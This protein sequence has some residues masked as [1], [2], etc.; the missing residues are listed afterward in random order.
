MKILKIYLFHFRNQ[1]MRHKLGLAIGGGVTATLALVSPFSKQLRCAMILSIP[2]LLCGRGRSL[3]MTLGMGI[4]VD[5][6]IENISENLQEV[7]QSIT[8]MYEKIK[9]LL[10]NFTVNIES[11]MD[12]F[13]EVFRLIRDNTRRRLEQIEKKLDNATRAVRRKLE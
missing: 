13:N 12:Q 2:N 5:G 11:I 3:L 4:I 7:V 6:P 10:C 8:C 1:Q 9:F